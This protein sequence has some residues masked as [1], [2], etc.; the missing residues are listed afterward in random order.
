M[1]YGARSLPSGMAV[2]ETGGK[3]V[4]GFEWGD[5][6]ITCPRKPGIEDL[7]RGDRR[8]DR[9]V[10]H[11]RRD[12]HSADGPEQ[13][14]PERLCVRRIDADEIRYTAGQQIAEQTKSGA[15]HCPGPICHAIAVRGCQ[16]A[17]GVESKTLPR[18][19]LNR[20]VS[21]WSMSCEIESN[22]PENRASAT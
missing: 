13:T 5:R 14:T 9:T 16:I 17:T 20:R 1:K 18:L 15:N 21:G 10:W 22:D 19:R 12:C 7:I 11:A 3:H 8:I 2:T 6:S 4:F